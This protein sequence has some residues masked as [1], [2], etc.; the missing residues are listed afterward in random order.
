MSAAVFW[1]VAAVLLGILEVVSLDFVL[2]ML[3]AGAL[4]GAGAAALGAPFIVQAGAAAAVAV[5]GILAVRPIA[6][7]HLKSGPAALT[8]VDALIG[9]KATVVE[10]VTADAGRV[11]IGGEIWSAQ[12]EDAWDPLSAGS[13]GTVVAIRGATA[14]IRPY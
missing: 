6:L 14:I 7:K 1:L 13:T 10:E 12:L 5:L 8:G 4:A 3:A 9:Q 2:I 11:K